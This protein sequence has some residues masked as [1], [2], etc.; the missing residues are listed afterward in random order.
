[1]SGPEL[2]NLRNDPSETRNVAE[3]FPA[4]LQELLELAEKARADLGD[5]LTGKKGSGVREPGRL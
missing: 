5:D 1:M 3:Q 2:Y 4:P